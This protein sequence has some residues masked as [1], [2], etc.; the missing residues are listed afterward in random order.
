MGFY[1][2]L[3]YLQLHYFEILGTLTGLIYVF[4]SIEQKRILWIYGGISSLFYIVVFGQAGLFAYMTLYFYYTGISIYGWFAWAKTQKET[5]GTSGIT[6]LNARSWIITGSV[7][8]LLFLILGFVLKYTANAEIAWADALL[9]SGSIAAT[10]LL[11]RKVIDHWLLWIGI[12]TL[13]GFVSLYK[14]LP[15][16]AILFFIY[17]LLAIKGF[18]E[19]KKRLTQTLHP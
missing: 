7:I 10:W 17:T 19:W 4:Y 9:T 5:P 13:S 1:P 18:F 6:Q 11:M 12:D 2:F 8:V 3:H 14:G 16:A 15:F